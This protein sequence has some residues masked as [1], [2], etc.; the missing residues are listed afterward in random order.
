MSK[1]KSLRKLL[2]TG[3]LSFGFC[4]VLM[5]INTTEGFAHGYITTSRAALAKYGYNTNAGNVQY[6]PQSVEGKGNFPLSGP[7]DG[8]LASAGIFLE[9][10]EQSEDRWTKI[11]MQSGK[12]T[13]DWTLT[14]PHRTSEFK[15][16]IT[17]K[18]WD[19]NKAITRDD[20]EEIAR[21]DGNNEIPEPSVSHTINIP[22]DRDG[23]H[24]ILGV[25]EVADTSNAFYQVID[26]D[27]NN[28]NVVEDTE[29]PT[30]PVNLT[31]NTQTSNSISLNWNESSDNVGVHHYDIYRNNVKVGSSKTTDFTDINLK[32]NTE[33][34]YIVKAIDNSGNES[35][36]SNKI[37]IKT[38]ELPLVDTEAPTA[39]KNLHSMGETESSIDLHWMESSDNVAID[40]YKI[41]RDGILIHTT[42]TNRF[43]D[44]NLKAN[45][46][47]KYEVEAV[48]SSGNVSEKSNLL[49]IKTK[50]KTE[51]NSTWSEST[52]YIGG[53]IV[54]YNGLEYKAKWWTKGDTPGKSDVWELLTKDVIT[55]WSSDLAYNADDIVTFDGKKYKAKWWTKGDK[56]S[57]SNVW[58]EI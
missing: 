24:V 19:P 31:S 13:F 57:S 48:D 27:L 15:Y 1:N 26:V 37:T 7:Q 4:M 14:A 32:A 54:I 28:D 30:A 45:T 10:D 55:E 8:Q 53:E 9:L 34:T 51:E 22:S 47:Y 6:E 16:Y 49:V 33:Y 56:P 39:P 44:T 12:N 42:S 41:Y 2:T 52:T 58:I 25:W 46:E 36:E 17:K 21:I 29:A 3:A 50:D 35:L 23:Y 43:K 18:G 11:P 38:K 5:G 40:K 20:L